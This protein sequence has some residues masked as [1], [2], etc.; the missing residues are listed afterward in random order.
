MSYENNPEFV[1]HKLY[2]ENF[3][4]WDFNFD[5]SSE[6][7]TL[8]TLI[9]KYIWENTDSGREILYNKPSYSK[10]VYLEELK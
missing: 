5:K 10:E 6:P 8:F 2:F 3:K 7:S 9:T 4:G 1:S